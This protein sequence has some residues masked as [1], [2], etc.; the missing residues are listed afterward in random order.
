MNHIYNGEE[1][2][3]QTRFAARKFQIF[4]KVKMVN[5]HDAIKNILNSAY[6]DICHS[7]TSR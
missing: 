3:I 2:G 4:T 7:C 5:M 1:K 6:Y